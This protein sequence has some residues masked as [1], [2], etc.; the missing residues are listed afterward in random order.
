MH[1]HVFGE[2]ARAGLAY[3][4]ATVGSDDNAWTVGAGWAYSRYYENEYGPSCLT[5]PYQ[6][7]EPTRVAQMEGSPVL[8]VGGE[9]RISR[10]GK[11]ISENYVFDGGGIASFGVRFLGERLSADLGLAIP[12]GVDQFIAVP[13]VNFVWTFGR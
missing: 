12:L 3:G 4:V 9:R 7:C 11:F 6:P 2:D 10:R 5:V 13:V 1:F 8:M